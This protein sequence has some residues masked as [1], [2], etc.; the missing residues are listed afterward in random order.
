M[1]KDLTPVSVLKDIVIENELDY[2][3]GF[4]LCSNDELAKIYNGCGPDWLSEE[5]REKLTDYYTFFQAAFLVHD[6]DFARAD[7]TREGF[8]AANKRLYDN[9]VKLI[10]ARY[11]WWTEPISKARR[12]LQARVIYRAC[13][14]FG[15]SAW[16]D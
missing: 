9:C 12:Y 14:Y 16:I 4:L 13:A 15:W 7:K 10:A 1:N 8:N 3:N 6:Y 5:M 2:Q 11:S